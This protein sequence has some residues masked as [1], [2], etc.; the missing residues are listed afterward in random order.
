ML[1]DELTICPG[2]GDQ[3]AAVP[4]QDF[5]LHVE[6]LVPPTSPTLS[7]QER[8]NSGIYLQGRY[9]VQVLDSFGARLADQ[10]D[11]AAI[12]A[13]KDAGTN[14][15]R[16]SGTWQSYD[17]EFHAARFAADGSK[18]AN[19]RLSLWWNGTLV[20]SDVE[21]PGPTHG[22]AIESAAP[23]PI[24]LQDHGNPVRYRN[25]WLQPLDS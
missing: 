6:F 17:V 16:P 10:N 18:A 19:A 5:R 4:H 1:W 11:A 20:H 21:P 3:H 22:G 2:C 15:A 25:V 12:Y 23:G 9:E 13:V 8:G 7:E 14:A 24:V